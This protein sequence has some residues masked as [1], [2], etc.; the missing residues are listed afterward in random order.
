MLLVGKLRPRKEKGLEVLLSQGQWPGLCPQCQR[1]SVYPVSSLKHA[2]VR[3]ARSP[4]TLT[5][6]LSYMRLNV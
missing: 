6:K 2:T 1:H 5:L 4:E 3:P